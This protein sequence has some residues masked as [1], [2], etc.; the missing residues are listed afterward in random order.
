MCLCMDNKVCFD[1]KLDEIVAR[2]DW[3]DWD[4]YVEDYIWQRQ[5]RGIKTTLYMLGLFSLHVCGSMLLKD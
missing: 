3:D 5:L 4:A 2:I 1:C